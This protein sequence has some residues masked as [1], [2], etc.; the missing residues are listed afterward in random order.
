MYHP[1]VSGGISHL[2]AAGITLKQDTASDACVSRWDERPLIEGLVP[3][4]ASLARL[5]ELPT[6]WEGESHEIKSSVQYCHTARRA[7][8][9]AGGVPSGIRA[10]GN[11][12]AT[13]DR[14]AGGGSRNRAGGQPEPAPR[15]PQ[16]AGENGHRL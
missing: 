13:G 6:V 2:D 3:R 9:D 12:A 7:C 16:G 5:P 10:D 15:D 11:G 8:R 1:D 14:R 4:R